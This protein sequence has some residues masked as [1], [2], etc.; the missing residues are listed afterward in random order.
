METK[1]VMTLIGREQAIIGKTFR[2]YSIPN[3]CRQCKL[4]NICVA[5]S[6]QVGSIELLRSSMLACHNLTSAF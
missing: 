1:R 2:L 4:F 6:S 5:S 3:E